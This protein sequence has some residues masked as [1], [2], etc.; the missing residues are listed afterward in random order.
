VI[1]IVL[2]PVELPLRLGVLPY[3]DATSSEAWPEVIERLLRALTTRPPAPAS[4]A[5]AWPGRPDAGEAAAFTAA[6][7]GVASPR[8]WYS[9]AV[10][11]HLDRLQAEVDAL[12]ARRSSQFGL[13]AR[14]VQ[15]GTL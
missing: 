5:P 10:Y 2:H 15:V 9:L 8:V 14:R 7:P 1:L 12:I 11:I 4:F 6:S 13:W 3:L